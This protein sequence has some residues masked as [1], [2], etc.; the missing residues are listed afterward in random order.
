ME[1]RIAPL[2]KAGTEVEYRKYK[3]L[4]Y[5]FGRGTGTSAAG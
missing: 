5:G 2:G 1:R 3:D 4:G